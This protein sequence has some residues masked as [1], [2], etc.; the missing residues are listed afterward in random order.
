[1]KVLNCENSAAFKIGL[2]KIVGQTQQVPKKIKMKLDQGPGESNDHSRFFCHLA[3]F[4]LEEKSSGPIKPN[5][6]HPNA[7]GPR[8][9]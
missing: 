7:Q 4:A 2:N 8:R 1:M 9:L 5:I 6:Q 3:H